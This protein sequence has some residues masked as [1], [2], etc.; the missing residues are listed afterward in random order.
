MV[1][2]AAKPDDLETLVAR[3]LSALDEGR[4]EVVDE[5]CAINAHQADAIRNRLASLEGLGV[6]VAAVP[7]RIGPYRILK[8]IGEGGMGSV[9]LAEQLQPVKRRVALKV[10]KLGMDSKQVLA[11]FDRERQALALMNHDHIARV[12]DAGT[13]PQGQ[14]YFV[15]EHVAGVPVTDYCEQNNVSLRERIQLFKMICSG[16]THA[17][18]KGVIHRDLKP[19]NILVS[20]QQGNAVPKIIDF[21][22]ARA[23]AQPLMERSLFTE[24]GQILGTPEYMSPEQAE[25]STSD[26]DTRTDVYSLGVVLYE[27]LVGTLPFDSKELRHVEL[28]EMRRKIQEDEPPKPSARISRIGRGRRVA[29]AQQMS[30][31]GLLRALRT[32]L[33][34][35]ALKAME[36][37]RS[38]RYDTAAAMADDLQRFLDDIPVLAGPPSAIYRMRKLVRRNRAFVL[39]LAAVFMT[40]IGGLLSAAWEGE[41]NRKRT[42]FIFEFILGEVGPLMSLTPQ[43]RLESG[44][45][46]EAIEQTI[47]VLGESAAREIGENFE[48]ILIGA[49]DE[50]L[51]AQEKT[52]VRMIIN[53]F[54][55]D[56]PWRFSDQIYGKGREEDF[57]GQDN[58]NR[59]LAHQGNL[60]RW[61][62]AHQD[63]LNRWTLAVLTA[64]T[65]EEVFAG[66]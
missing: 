35:I 65:V 61:S 46:R 38:R 64:E 20:V 36:K 3:C 66:H 15:M 55:A 13:T 24:V 9:F 41:D 32:D 56:A 27:L 23:T 31:S 12:F 18:Q 57:A 52:L 45:F 30:L 6:T 10:I 29:A 43:A 5:I 39:G 16:V 49:R 53:R 14:P 44:Q 25:M 17:H 7:S 26:I 47:D 48:L 54:G 58:L 59:Y 40:A 33:D 50:C 21:G 62:L 42:S 60:N 22:L 8:R 28:M 2:D 63:D 51:S 37:E 4:A 19:S 34:W 1:D 11:R